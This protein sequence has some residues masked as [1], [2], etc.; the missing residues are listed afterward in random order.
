M[1]PEGLISVEVVY[2]LP[3]AQEVIALEVPCGATVAEAIGASGLSAHHGISPALAQVGIHG[4]RVAPDTVL[5]SGDRVEIY[6][7]LIA[8]P[9]LA[10]RRRAA[11]S[12]S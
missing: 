10:R 4:R 3:D 1:A 9:K 8:D 12:G 6:R 11:R 7:A 2:A 5:R